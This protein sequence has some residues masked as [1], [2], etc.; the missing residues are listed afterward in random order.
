MKTKKLLNIL[1]FVGAVIKSDFPLPITECFLFDNGKIISNDLTTTV[2]ADTDIKGTFLIDKKFL[3]GILGKRSIKEVTFSVDG[4]EVVIKAVDGP[5][6]FRTKFYP[7]SVDEFPKLIKCT[8]KVGSLTAT[9]MDLISKAKQ[10]TCINELRPALNGVYLCHTAKEYSATD[11]H[12]LT[13]RAL[14]GK[15]EEDYIIHRNVIGLFKGFGDCEL[16]S[17]KDGM[18]LQFDNKQGLK[19]ITRPIDGKFPNYRAVIPQNHKISFRCDRKEFNRVIGEAKVCT[20]QYTHTIVLDIKKGKD[21]ITIKADDLDSG[22]S[23]KSIVNGHLEMEEKELK[24]GFN[25][26]FLQKCLSYIPDDD[27]EVKFKAANRSITINDEVLLMPVV[28][29]N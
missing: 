24:I 19:I 3:M 15:F 2:I 23:F 7:K 10:F 12:I 1:K 13:W 22:H 6:E 26:L 29:N 11:A 4:S 14:E 17:G 27:V 28:M 18:Y 16:S 21:Y 5:Q 20:N 25:A 8:K 9:D